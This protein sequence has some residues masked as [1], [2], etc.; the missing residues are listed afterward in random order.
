MRHLMFH[1]MLGMAIVVLAGCATAPSPYTPTP[2]GAKEF[3]LTMR[4]G[5]F[6]PN[7]LNV[8][9]GDRVRLVISSYYQF[10]FFNFNE[11]NISRMVSHDAPEVVEFV[12]AKPGWFDF[13]AHAF[14]SLYGRLTL[15]GGAEG[16]GSAEHVLYGRLYVQ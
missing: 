10:A 1:L 11:F 6:S 5:A 14:N 9:T 2:D 12:A 13:T 7:Y 16:T 4:A 15:A 3:A 8:N